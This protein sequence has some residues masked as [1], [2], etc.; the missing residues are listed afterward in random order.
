MTLSMTLNLNGFI[1]HS[2][3]RGPLQVAVRYD[4]NPAEGSRAGGGVETD[5]GGVR[6]SAHI[7]GE[8]SCCK[9][10]QSC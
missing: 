4:A 10:Q 8:T 6:P 3:L 9:N 1:L 5:L 2:E 7:G